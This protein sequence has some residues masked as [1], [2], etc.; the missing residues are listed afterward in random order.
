MKRSI[1]ITGVSTGNQGF[2][3]K[4]SNPIQF[5]ITNYVESK[6]F[7]FDE[8]WNYASNKPF[9]KVNYMISIENFFWITGDVNIWKTDEELNILIQYNS[10][11]YNFGY[12]GLYFNSKSNLIYVVSY[13]LN[14]I[15]EFNLN[16]T[17]NNISIETPYYPWSING[18]NNQLYVSTESGMIFV[19]VDKQ[20]MR[21]FNGCNGKNFQIYSLLF[22][23]YDNMATACDNFQLYLYNRNGDYLNKTIQTVDYPCFIGFDFKSR[24]VVVGDNQIS[25]YY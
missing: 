13:S 5:Y 4:T 15:K 11:G 14:L 23:E 24:L 12:S 3:M 25:L 7:I 19:I 21:N 9:K 18:Y 22:D 8:D 2:G 10:T 6:I 20:I 1:S 17:V 16:V